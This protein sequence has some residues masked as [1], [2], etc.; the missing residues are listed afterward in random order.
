MELQN[1]EIINEIIEYFDG[2]R[3]G[4]IRDEICELIHI[5]EKRINFNGDY[6]VK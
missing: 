4:Y 3:V 6:K 5:K 1:E 2:K